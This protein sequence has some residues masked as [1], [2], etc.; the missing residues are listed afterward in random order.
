M[1]SNSKKFL[2]IHVPK[3]A[4]NAVQKVLMPYS[5]DKI[6]RESHKD[7][8]LNDFEVENELG[9]CRK[10][11]WI[12]PYIEN[13]DILERPISEYFKFAVVRNP[14]ERMVSW[15][16]YTFPRISQNVD[17][18]H[19]LEN[20]LGKNMPAMKE[21]LFYDGQNQMDYIIRYENLEQ[22]LIDVCKKIDIP[23]AGFEVTNASKHPH[24]SHFYNDQSLDKIQELYREDIEIFNYSY[25][26]S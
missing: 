17:K 13:A 21:Y 9:I 4:G 24:Y 16:C 14:W 19:F 25:E 6:Y 26:N 1:K 20:G 23:F 10:H 3:T 22:G 15:Y 2:F 7:G 12:G 5:D 11:E 18:A 8:K